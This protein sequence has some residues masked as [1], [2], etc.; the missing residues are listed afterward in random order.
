MQNDQI[1]TKAGQIEVSVKTGYL[2]C[3]EISQR[4]TFFRQLFE[5]H[6]ALMLLIDADS[7]QI[8]GANQAAANFYGWTRAELC[9]KT[10][11]QIEVHPSSKT[12]ADQET[13]K[14]PVQNRYSANHRRAD[15][16]VCD[17]E[18]FSSTIDLQGKS[19]FHSIIQDIS[20]RKRFEALTE[21]RIRLI[22]MAERSSTEALLT[23]TLD[24]AE[25]LTGSSIGFF[26]FVS[27]DQSHI[28]RHA[29]S[30]CS[31]QD[32]CGNAIHPTVIKS[33][34]CEDVV[35]NQRAVIHNNYSTLRHCNIEL[36]DHK[37]VG[38]ELIVPIIRNGSV[39]ATLEI[40]NKTVDYDDNDI[41][42]LSILA[43]VA[44][45]I[46]AKKYAEESEQKMQAVVQYTQKMELIGQLAGGVAHDINNVLTSILGHAELVLDDINHAGPHNES[47]QS[48]R[49]SAIRAANLIDQL[50][51]FARKQTI[52]PKILELDA[53]IGELYPV[54]QK[55][56]GKDAVFKWHPG[57][58][59]SKVLIDPTQLDQI[60]T[61]LCVNASDAIIA[62]GTIT[63]DTAI[64]K[65]ERSDCYAG[66]TCQTP[67]D[68]VRISVVDTGSGIDESVLP[69]IFEPFF[70]TKE[71]G[72]GTGMGLSTVYGIV[73]QNNG[74]IDC[75]SLAGKGTS[76]NIFL[77][78]VQG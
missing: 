37:E 28:L 51:A 40:G 73:K 7:G 64:V 29:C 9:Q 18:I 67:G 33:G 13:F 74:Y 78:K 10:M 42:L 76:F 30:T 25:R 61:N 55:L 14:T 27:N 62:S 47:L 4:E 66:H 54:L 53:A 48:I 68:F 3:P 75:L 16:S 65:V 60:I 6:A 5:S 20:E 46:I 70:T 71:F 43:G 45:D 72:K 59:Q 34:V 24:E 39:M 21:F 52:Q 22:E 19:F 69:H 12:T 8:V 23:F 32:N 1:I 41:K 58:K 36:V 26:N 17:V 49:N 63:I 38:R 15:G 11:Q 31:K 35:N 77:P 50:L 57:S 2:D 56:V 44:W